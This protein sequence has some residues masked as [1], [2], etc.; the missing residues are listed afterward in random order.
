VDIYYSGL[1]VWWLARC[2]VCWVVVVVGLCG[3]HLDVPCL[4]WWADFT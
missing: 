4:V 3:E 2:F 1:V